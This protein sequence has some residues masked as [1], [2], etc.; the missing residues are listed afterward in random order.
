MFNSVLYNLRSGHIFVSL[1]ET[2]R[3]ETRMKN[4]LYQAT[5]LENMRA[6][7]EFRPITCYVLQA[8]HV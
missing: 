3:R 7:L 4:R 5:T 8:F 2:L 1:G 6:M